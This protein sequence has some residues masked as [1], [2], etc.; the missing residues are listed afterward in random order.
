M[1]TN[2]P[3]FT[4]C[5]PS[6]NRDG[7][8]IQN[9]Q[10][11]RSL[12]EQLEQIFRV[13]VSISGQVRDKSR[14]ERLQSPGIAMSFVPQVVDASE[15]L[16]NAIRNSSTEYCLLAGDDDLF[17]PDFLLE[18][19]RATSQ[20][21]L[22]AA[23]ILGGL[24]PEIQARRDVSK[25]ETFMRS[26]ALPGLV[27][28]RELALIALEEAE[29]IFIGGIYPQVWV[30]LRSAD[31][32]FTQQIPGALLRSLVDDD[33]ATRMKT[34]PSDYGL[35]ERY[36][37]AWVALR[38]SLLSIIEFTECTVR[39]S[40]WALEISAQLRR[41]TGSSDLFR[42]LTFPREAVL[43]KIIVA[44][45]I[46]GAKSKIAKLFIKVRLWGRKWNRKS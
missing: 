20:G 38:S 36:F 11:L 39:L 40:S 34:R 24:Y 1:P 37:Y 35:S 8:L 13:S 44:F 28:R 15:N 19:S 30:A 23:L 2:L 9:L 27:V 12:Q 5:I 7:I 18:V 32:G 22:K 4:I 42:N 45:S 46:V 31:K 29:S 26:G 33:V 14:I 43:L 41:D 10:H 21:D 25:A 6:R 16:K 3:S 17:Q